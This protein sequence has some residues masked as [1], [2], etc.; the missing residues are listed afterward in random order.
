MRLTADVA[1][2]DD[3]SWHAK[4]WLDSTIF[5]TAHRIAGD[6]TAS[7]PARVFAIRYLLTLRKPQHVYLYEN[8]I[9]GAAGTDSQGQPVALVGCRGM[10]GSH[11]HASVGTPLPSNAASQVSALFAQLRADST[12]PEIVRKAAE[13]G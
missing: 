9:Q 2:L 12:A 7:A 11:G 4:S 5:A 10:M 8:L 1:S 3:F 13:C 6:P